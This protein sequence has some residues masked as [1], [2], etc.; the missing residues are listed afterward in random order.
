VPACFGP[1]IHALELDAALFELAQRNRPDHRAGVLDD[2]QRGVGRCRIREIAV[3]R[4][5]ELEAEFGQRFGDE[6][7]KA[8][9][10]ARLERDD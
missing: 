5:I 10:V 9:R 2:P 1:Q 7:T 3:E 8:F 6:R 4:R